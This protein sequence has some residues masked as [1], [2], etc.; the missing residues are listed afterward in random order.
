M[1]IRT[2][3]AGMFL[4]RLGVFALFC[5]GACGWFVYDGSITY[6]NQRERALKFREIKYVDPN[7]EELRPDWRDEWNAVA[8]ERGW[9]TEDPGA[10]KKEAEITTQFILGGVTGVI[11]IPFTFFFLRNRNRWI[12]A[13]DQGLRTS[14]GRQCKFSDIT[15]LDKKKWKYKGIAK[16]R[17][18]S[19]GRGGQIVLDDWK[20]TTD[21]TVEIL[22]RVESHID[23][24]LIVNGRPEPPPKPETT[25]ETDGDAPDP[26]SD[27]AVTDTDNSPV[28]ESPVDENTVDT[29]GESSK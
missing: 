2:D 18:K 3:I 26:S 5:I 21:P 25:D 8:A 15:A 29:S 12:E 23:H 27:N 19:N 1:T 10:P 22:R 28:D 7:S 17:Y 4:L 14:W 13:D 11:A 24:A 16:V 20:Y 6:P 9:P